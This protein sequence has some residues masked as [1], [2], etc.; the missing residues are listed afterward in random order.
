MSFP[1]KELWVPVD[2]LLAV[3]SQVVFM[4]VWTLGKNNLLVKG[5]NSVGI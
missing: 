1:L 4:C 2:K 5:D 3:Q